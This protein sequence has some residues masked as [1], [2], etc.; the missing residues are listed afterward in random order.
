MFKVNM[1][2]RNNYIDFM[3]NSILTLETNKDYSNLNQKWSEKF[4]ARLCN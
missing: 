3:S 1:A 4:D 2:L